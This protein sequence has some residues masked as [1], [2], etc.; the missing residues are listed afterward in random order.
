MNYIKAERIFLKNLPTL[1]EKWVQDKLAEDPAL[2]SLGDIIL[3]DKERLQ[4]GAG[5]L[6]LLFQ[7]A[8]NPIRYEAEI[9]LGKTD[10]SHIIR[11][12]EYWDIER[13]RYPQYD[14]VAVLVAEDITS[15]FLNV[16]SLFN[17]FIPIIAYQLQAYKFGD[18]I[19]LVFTKVLD[20]T[21][22]GLVEEDEGKFEIADRS[23]WVKRSSKKMMEL[24]DKLAEKVLSIDSKLSLKYNKFYLGLTYEG[25]ANNFIYFKPKKEWVWVGIRLDKS[26]EIDKK[27]DELGYD[28]VEY[29]IRWN[30]YQIRVTNDDGEEQLNYLYELFKTAYKEAIEK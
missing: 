14:H 15:R 11:A 2:L 30:K 16:I 10:E 1:D 26:E 5:R 17:G 7:D 25:I 21:R 20:L 3:K 24:T 13:K 9:Q 8:D 27:L 28:A 4:P 6:D 22:I 19:S 29:D 18:N 12:I 23:Y